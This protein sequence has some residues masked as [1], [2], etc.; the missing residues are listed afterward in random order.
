M[1]VNTLLD[2]LVGINNLV[3]DLKNKK[4]KDLEYE[5]DDEH[6]KY[7]VGMNPIFRGLGN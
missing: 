2:R 7:E 5:I 1:K 3:K 4:L 6:K